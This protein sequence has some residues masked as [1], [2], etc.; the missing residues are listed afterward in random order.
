MARS[1]RKIA[2]FDTYTYGAK[3][4]SKKTKSG[5]RIDRSKPRD[6][7]DPLFCKKGDTY[8][9]WTFRYGGMRR[10]KTP[11][12]QSQLTQ[13]EFLS[14]FYSIQEEISEMTD[15]ES[16][17]DI[18]SRIE[19]LRDDQEEK[20]SNMPEQLQDSASGEML[21]ERYDAL[22]E[23][24][25]DLDSIDLDTEINEE[26]ALHGNEGLDDFEKEALME[27]AREERIQEIIEQ[28]QSTDCSL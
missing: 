7:S 15:L 26:A 2:G 20:R 5:F 6:E 16:F 22:D 11:P 18:K 10:S 14:E 9:E 17:D 23:W 3:K 13:S 8:Y 28:I 21:Q 12:K 25:S 19:Q 1:H 4:P 24:V 27:D